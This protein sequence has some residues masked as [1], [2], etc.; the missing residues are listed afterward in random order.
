M[1]EVDSL[2]VDTSR[3]GLIIR[4]HGRGLIERKQQTIQEI[5]EVMKEH[6]ATTV[7]IDLREVPPPYVFMDRYKIGEL[8][9]RHFAGLSIAA[10]V[11]AAQAGEQKIGTLVAANRG[12]PVQLF[13]EAARAERWLN[14]QARPKPVA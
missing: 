8:V 1:A 10:L 12:V 9:A 13:T 6:R 4:L 5:M 11:N 14:Q 7:L 2:Q 3:G